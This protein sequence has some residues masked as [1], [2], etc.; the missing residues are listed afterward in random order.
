MPHVG[1]GQ[2]SGWSN[3]QRCLPA[4][5]SGRGFIVILRIYIPMLA[6]PGDIGKDKLEYLRIR[7]PYILAR[8]MGN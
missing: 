4:K 1:V 3:R 5:L 6:L 2:S 7:A 8:A